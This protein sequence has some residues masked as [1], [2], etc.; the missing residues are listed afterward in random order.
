MSYLLE[1]I[2]PQL[3]ALKAQ[4]KKIVTTNGCFDLLHKGHVTYL[5]EAKK[6]GDILVIGV[7]SDASVK[8]LK[9][10]TRPV[11]AATDRAFV[12]L[13]LKAVDF[14]FIFE[15]QRPIEFIKK[16]KPHYHVKGGDYEAQKLPEYEVLKSLGAE[17]KIIPFVE[18]YSTTSILS[19]L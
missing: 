16:I 15:E 7:N 6:V 3:E 1:D 8:S 9:G 11:N 14:V 18:G 2:L 13:G 19:K 10:D 12:L 5:N 4:G 17:I